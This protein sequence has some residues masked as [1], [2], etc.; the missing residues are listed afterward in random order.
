VVGIA[1]LMAAHDLVGVLGHG[2]GGGGHGLGE[3]VAYAR[4]AGRASGGAGA[5]AASVPTNRVTTRPTST[6]TN[7]DLPC[8][9]QT[10]SQESGGWGPD[11]GR[12]SFRECWGE[13]TSGSDRRA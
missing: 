11:A 7:E 1:G 9:S 5:A 2:R 12:A 8:S 3:A 6:G 4:M 13:R 10:R